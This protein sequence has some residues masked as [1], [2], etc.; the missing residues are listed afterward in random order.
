MDLGSV[1]N[2][3][4]TRLI[5]ENAYAVSYNLQFSSDN[6][7]WTTVYSTTNG[8]GSIND[9]GALGT[10]RYVRVYATQRGTQYGDS[11]WEF[12]VYPTPQ[13]VAISGISPTAGSVLVDPSTPFSFT[14]S[15]TVTNIATNAVQLILNGIDVSPLLAFSGTS[16]N[17]TVTFPF[18]QTNCFY[19]YA[20]QVADAAGNTASAI[21]SNAF[22]TFSQNNLMIEA[23]DFDFGG[24]KF[25]DNPSPSAIPASSSY[26][27]EATPAVVGIDVTTPGN[28]SGEQFAYRNDSCGTQ[29]AADFL[30]QKFIAA[31][32]SDYNVG[33][34]YTG[35]WLNYTRT[36]PANN[37]YIY[38]RLSGGNGAYTASAGLV[39][40]GRGTS[41]QTALSLGSFSGVDSNWQ[42]WQWVPLMNAG[43]QSAVVNLS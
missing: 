21:A 11:L 31:G 30:R 15:S 22:D 32:V 2:I 35:A 25:I 37:Y 36:F 34:W 4:R 27:M 9:L 20:I 26:Y 41:S 43:G 7:N 38:G 17:W 1:Q 40:A 33:W 8:P 12:E 23:E 29:P 28:S 14:V 5:W 24:G 3:T 39:T 10:G 42:G 19:S 6:T 13:A 16:N 18:L